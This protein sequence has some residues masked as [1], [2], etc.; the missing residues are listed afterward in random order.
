MWLTRASM[1]CAFGVGVLIVACSSD[2]KPPRP[3]PRDSGGGSDNGGGGGTGGT[4]GGFG[5][6]GGVGGFDT[7]D[8][9]TGDAGCVSCKP[10]G[11]QYCGRIG[12]GCTHLPLDCGMTCD[13]PGYTCGG[14]GTPN[15]CGT[16]PDAGPC[17][18]TVCDHGS[19]G[20]YCGQVGNG[21]GGTIDCGGCPNGLACGAVTTGVCGPAP[22]AGPCAKAVC[23]PPGGDYCGTIGDNCGGSLVC[24]P[25]PGSFT[26]AGSGVPNLCGADRDAGCVPT[27]CD[28]GAA[29]QRCGIVGDGCGGQMDC[30]ACASGY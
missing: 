24:P 29:G 16:T 27:I 9:T 2:P 8:A 6:G 30:G 15:V 21:C 17:K 10:P 19:A 1:A 3:P 22:D 13:E 26:C 23:N 4:T 12:S 11:G 25:C 5:V 14:A 18:V 28:L 20:K 7:V